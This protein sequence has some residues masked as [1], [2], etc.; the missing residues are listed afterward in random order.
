MPLPFIAAIGIPTL[1]ASAF[2]A[3]TNWFSGSKNRTHSQEIA[4]YNVEQQ[5]KLETQ[6]QQMQV[7]QLKLNYLQHRENQSFQAEQAQLNREYQAELETFRQQVQREISQDNLRFQ[8]WRLEQEQALQQQLAVYGRETQQLLAAYQR[9]TAR[10]QPEVNKLYET[11]PLRIVPMQIL[12]DPPVNGHPPLKVIIAPPEVD[13]DKFGANVTGVPKLEKGLAE[14]LRTFLGKHYPAGDRLRPVEFIGGA[15]DAKRFH[16]EASIAALFSM[17]RGESLLVLESEIDGDCLNMRF[18]YWAA[19]QERP[20]Y[21]P[22]LTGFRFRD[23]V[24]ES[25]RERARKWKAPHDLLLA[26]GKNPAQLNELD[27]CNLN[28]LAEDA[29]LAQFGV[30]V[31]QL[32]PRYRVRADDFEL[33][34]DFLAFNHHLVTGLMADIHHLLQHDSPPLLAQ[35]L[36]EML[37]AGVHIEALQPVLDTYAGILQQLAEL[38]PLWAAELALELAHNLAGFPDKGWAESLLQ[39]A[40]GDWLRGHDLPA[41][42]TRETALAA[43]PDHAVV[44]DIP[45]LEKLH[46]CLKALGLDK[47]AADIARDLGY[48][49]RFR[50]HIPAPPVPVFVPGQ[51]FRDHP[52]AP[53]LVVLPRGSFL[54]GSEEYK[55]TEPVHRV[56]IDYDLAVGKYPVTFEEWDAFA[57]ETGGYRPP[58]DV[59]CWGRGRCPVM[60]VSWDDAQDYVRWLSG[61][62]G[63]LYRLLSE[64]EWEYAA[65]AGTTTRFSFGDAES[66]LGDYAWYAD[67]SGEKTHP[68]GEKRAN[69]FGLHDMYGNVWEWVQDYWT[70]NYNNAPNNGGAVVESNDCAKRVLRGGSWNDGSRYFQSAYRFTYSSDF[71]V[72]VI[73]FRVARTLR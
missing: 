8:A 61:K 66:R 3:A 28:I 6:R 70:D 7:A 59:D 53:E 13:F 38:R 32:P 40:L 26:Q 55:T 14:A 4:R 2:G 71:R 51:T 18:A 23:L 41:A 65:R 62:T 73:G 11:W 63:K 25:A 30:D 68:V 57:A 12:K 15:W 58:D 69:T 50:Q 54:M 33:L 1:L 49:K 42:T 19:G 47:A 43:I 52:Q 64:S 34:K 60:H 31:S 16:G 37:A 20:F 67:N 5:G 27:T 48:L 46:D 29:E 24:Y 10:Q 72:I 39:Q 45:F 36:P 9:E 22:V 21:A 17:L 56:D 44:T 35:W